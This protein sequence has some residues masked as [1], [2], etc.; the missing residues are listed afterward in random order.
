MIVLEFGKLGHTIFM[1]FD[2]TMID[3]DSGNSCSCL[4]FTLH[5]DLGLIKYIFTDKTGTLTKNQ[6]KFINA[7]IVEKGTFEIK[8]Q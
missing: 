8:E 6:M 1:E 3:L 5:E 4:N 7:Y 2:A